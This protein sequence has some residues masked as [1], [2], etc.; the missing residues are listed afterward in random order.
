[1]ERI[2]LHYDMLGNRLSR[3]GEIELRYDKLGNRPKWLGG[4]ELHYDMLGNRPKYLTREG[5]AQLTKQEL[6]MVFFV[7]YE[8]LRERTS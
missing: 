4:I 6:V 3:I 1:M 2:E 8:H 7:L 5:S